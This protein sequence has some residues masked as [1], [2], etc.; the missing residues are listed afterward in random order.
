MTQAGY[1][2]AL[3]ILFSDPALLTDLQYNLVGH[4]SKGPF[5]QGV[6]TKNKFTDTPGLAN[7][8]ADNGRAAGYPQT[9]ALTAGSAAYRK[10]DKDLAGLGDPW[11]YDARG[12]TRSSTNA[13]IG[14]YDPDAT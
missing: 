1:T 3:D 5:Y 14:A 9:L 4:A 10:G 7:A 11:K 12:K 6:G 13:S 2:G 8:L